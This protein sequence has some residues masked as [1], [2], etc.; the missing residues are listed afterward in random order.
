MNELHSLRK[1]V[2]PALPVVHLHR[3]AL[4]HQ[5]KS[6]VT[7]SVVTMG[8]ETRSSFY[9]LVLLQAPAGYGK[10]TL[11]ADFAQHTGFSCCW[12]FLD[13]TDSDRITF[14]NVLLM[15]IRQ[16]FPDF[17][18]DLDTLLTG[19]ASEYANNPAKVNYFEMIVDALITAL[20]TEIPERF[21]LLLCNY[22]EINELQEMNALVS[23]FLQKL[24]PQCVLVIESRI[25]PNFDFA[26]LLAGQMVCG[27]GIDQLRFT[28]W[29]IHKLAQLQ[30]IGPFTDVEAEWMAR[31]FDGWIAGILLGTR[32]SNMRQFQQ[33]LSTSAFADL[34]DLLE[35]TVTSQYLFSYVVNEV[36]KSH[37][38]AHIF[39]KEAC[40]LQEMTPATC[41][42]LLGIPLFETAAHLHYLELKNLFVT[43]SGEGPDAVYTCTPVLRKLFYEQ[44]R[45][46]APERFSYL[47]QR[48]AELLSTTH[49]YSQAI[50]HALEASANEIAARLI[51][52]LAEQIMNQGHA[53]TLARWID[54][55]PPSTTHLYP[56]LLLIRSDIYLRQGNHNSA[57]PLLDAADNAVQTLA[58]QASSLDTHQLP[59]LQAEI[60]I[61]RGKLLFQR[62]EYLQGQL[63]CQQVL[64]NL[65]TDEIMLRAEALMR[66]GLCS[67]LL[68]ILPSGSLISRRLFSCGDDTL[69]DARQLMGIVR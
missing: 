68:A 18:R 10:T 63:F 33:S 13:H 29:Q 45:H 39:L 7:G 65:P 40:I 8:N 46:E 59:A 31:T 58:S 57:L 5:V 48:A 11:L 32:L 2:C 67:I 15:S 38:K 49:N 66:L 42:A 6:I 22:H 51:I 36:F 17:G 37:Q 56:K 21:A 62:R 4:V 60:V 43:H 24:P 61:A 64:A 54:T 50:Y 44:L 25:I 9:K 47:H 26:H 27:I 30:D 1:V 69:S 16:R 53:E 52:E 34:P 14:L 19:T 3:E 28:A 41:A 20:E 55:L 35:R 12:Y 23:Y